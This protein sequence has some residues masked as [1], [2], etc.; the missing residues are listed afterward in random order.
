MFCQR[1]PHPLRRNQMRRAGSTARHML[2]E[3]LALRNR[4]GTL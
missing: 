2:V 3:I 1:L 4:Q